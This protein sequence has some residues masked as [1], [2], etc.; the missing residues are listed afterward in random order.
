MLGQAGTAQLPSPGAMAVLGRLCTD[1]DVGFMVE[2][3]DARLNSL[4]I[5]E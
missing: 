2:H 3:L 4:L 5:L 1:P